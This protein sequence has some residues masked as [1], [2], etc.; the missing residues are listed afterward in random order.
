[1]ENKIRKPGEYMAYMLRIWPV[2]NQQKQ[3]WRASLENAQTGERVGFASL[4]ELFEYLGQ[5][6]GLNSEAGDR[7]Q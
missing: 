7:K 6:T 4:E 1:M 2:R 3:C 5:Q